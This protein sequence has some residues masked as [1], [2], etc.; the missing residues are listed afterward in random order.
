MP[1]TT[2]YPGQLWQEIA[3][4]RQFEV[5][6]VTELP[7]EEI[8]VGYTSRETGAKRTSLLTEWLERMSLIH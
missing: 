8:W 6:Q 4:G 3:S 5:S 1:Y 7:N 2:V